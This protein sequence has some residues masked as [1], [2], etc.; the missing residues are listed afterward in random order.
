M[1]PSSGVPQAQQLW[2]GQ[3]RNHVAGTRTLPDRIRRRYVMV[4][5]AMPTPVSR[6]T[7]DHRFG[8]TFSNVRWIS[9][10]VVYWMAF[11]RRICATCSTLAV[12]PVTVFSAPTTLASNLSPFSFSSGANIRFQWSGGGS[13]HRTSKPANLAGA[14][15]DV[16]Q[17]EKVVQHL[18]YMCPHP[19]QGSPPS[20]SRLHLG[21]PP[22][23][24]WRQN[25][26][27]FGAYVA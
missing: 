18:F 4:L 20:W 27:E 3:G 13:Q 8:L 14:E 11:E 5:F 10:S 25:L 22:R 21:L 2:R 12:S 24:V 17:I 23:A 19:V 26:T 9:P 7:I 6:T 1:V 15:K 16:G